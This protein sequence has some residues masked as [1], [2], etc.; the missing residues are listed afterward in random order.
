MTPKVVSITEGR[1]RRSKNGAAPAERPPSVPKAELY[2]AVARAI[3]G[4]DAGMLPAFPGRFHTVEPYPGV[5]NVIQELPGGLVRYVDPEALTYAVVAYTSR[6]LAGR[7]GF[8]WDVRQ[9]RAAADY[10]RAVTPPIAEPPA[11]RW[12]DEAGLAFSRL[13]W[14]FEWDPPDEGMPHF[15]ELLGRISN[16]PALAEW[17][18]SLFDAGSDRQQY[19]WLYG[20]GQNGKGALSRFLARVFGLAYRSTQPP[21]IHDKHWTAGLVGARLVVFPDCN[22]YGFPATG[23]FKSLSGGD[24][25]QIDQKYEKAYTASLA[26]KFMFLSNERPQLSSERADMRRAVYCEAAAIPGAV[27]PVYEERLWAEGGRFLSKCIHN[28]RTGYPQGGPIQVDSTQLEDWV[29][30]VEEDFEVLAGHYMAF[31]PYETCLQ[32]QWVA[33]CKEHLKD[34]KHKRDFTAYLERRHGVRFDKERRRNVRVGER[35]VKLY[36]GF[37]L[38][39]QFEQNAHD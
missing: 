12:A 29:A 36:T 7:P 11:V 37:R 14:P 24:A 26:A 38:R 39:S 8:S 9:A 34:A 20:T 4:A 13:P 27:D 6:E 32:S 17:I 18:G 3:G 5:R 1:A 28:Y 22:A 21:T 19:V 2:H 31:G 30:V 16:A 15:T 25:V 33:F 10:W 23:L 35:V